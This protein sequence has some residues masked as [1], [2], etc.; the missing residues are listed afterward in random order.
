MKQLTVGDLATILQLDASIKEDLEKKF[1]NYH[2]NLKDE[3]LKIL[4]NGVHELENRLAKVKYE[5]LLLE[6][7]E[8]KRQLTDNLYQE[9]MKA[10][11]QDFEDLLAGKTQ[12]KVKTEAQT[13]Q[14]REELKQI[15]NQPQPNP[16]PANNQPEVSEKQ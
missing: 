8:G 15:L 10:V 11:W 7:D 13:E 3:I 5:E 14:I 9:A 12:E 2:D 1:A 4:W 6:V 16:P